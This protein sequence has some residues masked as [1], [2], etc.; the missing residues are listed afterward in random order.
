MV[1]GALYEINF[2]ELHKNMEIVASLKFMV[3]F[4]EN[5]QAF[6][7]DKGEF[8]ADFLWDA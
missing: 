2:V 5:Q 1:D 8:Y 4:N 3:H 7:H 6:D